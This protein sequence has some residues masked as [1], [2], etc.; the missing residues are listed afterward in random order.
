M[1]LVGKIKPKQSAPT[2]H[3]EGN[4][5]QR[6]TPHRAEGRREGEKENERVRGATSIITTQNKKKKRKETV[7][8]NRP[9]KISLS[10]FRTRWSGGGGNKATEEEGNVRR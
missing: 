3:I 2:P 5:T 8:I 4:P 10:F 9:I 1:R 7:Q 6:E